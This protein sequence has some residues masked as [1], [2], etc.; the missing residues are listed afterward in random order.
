MEMPQENAKACPND[1]EDG[2]AST[3]TAA[4]QIAKL[5]AELERCKR[6]KIAIEER[7]N[8][9]VQDLEALKASYSGALEWA[10]SV[11]S[12]P[13]EHWLEKGH[14][15][16][17]A[18]AMEEFLNEFKLTIRELR[19]GT[20]KKG[21]NGVTFFLRDEEGHFVTAA[22]DELLMPYWKE[23]AKA[24]VH[25]SEYHA[26]EATLHFSIFCI[27]TPDAVLDVLR[28]A[29]KHSR[30]KCVCFTG[31]GT[32][33]TWKLPGFIEDIIQT[34]HTVT[35]VH[36]SGIMLSNAEWKS[37]C[38]EIRKRNLRQSSSS[39]VRSFR[40]CNGF[41]GRRI[42]TE[43]LKDILALASTAAAGGEGMH[44]NLA[45]NG[46][47]SQEATIIAEC[48][49]SNPSL[50]CLFLDG[51][52]F[53]DNDATL[54]ANSLSSNTNLSALGLST[55]TAIKVN[56]RD[57]F[58]R[59]VFDVSSL[60][61]CAASNHACHVTGLRPDISAL[62][63]C[64]EASVHKWEKIF[65]MLALTSD[66][67]FINTA[68]LS[69]VP[70]SLMPV[71]LYWA[72]EQYEESYHITDMYLDATNTNRRQKHDVWDDNEKTRKISCVY[73]LLRSW[74]VPSI[75]V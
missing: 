8:K 4:Q 59:A 73:E 60:A 72:N 63:C 54:L 26:G 69:G 29:V 42:H 62:N 51:N 70:A 9:A 47:A 33:K 40:L 5:Q 6:D 48:L 43:L 50:D 64:D 66:D 61:A 56:G 22:H 68:L 55:N 38:N 75:F 44:L 11:K 39:I 58:L 32:P 1:M 34:N 20:V 13:R 3:L 41:V 28:P 35:E 36:F 19:T 7:H 25:W 49:S 2:G 18:N 57:A 46:M 74:V 21:L 52:H 71:L 17:Y 12:I 45:M 15:E 37:I 16:V 67:S 14:S 65:A 30:L 24:L 27:E 53:N 10:Y 31:D 23:L